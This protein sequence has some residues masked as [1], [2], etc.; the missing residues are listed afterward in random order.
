MLKRTF[1]VEINDWDDGDKWNEDTLT[2]CIQKI[3]DLGLKAFAA[4]R[5]CF[6]HFYTLFISVPAL[7]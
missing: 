7:L 4:T 2:N 5:Y 3:H 6:I 1:L